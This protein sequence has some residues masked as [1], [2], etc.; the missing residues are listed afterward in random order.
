MQKP[1][2]IRVLQVIRQGL[3]GG[4]E[5][6]VIDIIKHIDR[7]RFKT[8][9]LS[10][11]DGPMISEI[12]KYGIPA[13]VISTNRAFDIPIWSSISKFI[14]KKQIELI[15][16]HGSRAQ[17]NVFWSALTNKLPLLYTVHGWSFHDDQSV[18]VRN[19]RGI[20]EK[21]LVRS[22][23]LVVNVSSSN[24]ATG[25]KRIGDYKGITIENGV[26]LKK[27]DSSILMTSKKKQSLG[28]SDDAVIIGCIMRMTK[29]KNPLGMLEAFYQAKQQNDKLCLLLVGDG[30]LMPEIRKFVEQHGLA[31]SVCITGS[32]TDVP[33]LL[34]V[35]D[36]FCLPSLWEGLPLSLLEAMAMEKAIIATNVDGT[37]ELIEDGSNGFLINPNDIS[38]I[39]ERILKLA[40]DKKLRK[41]FGA[42]SKS[43]IVQKHDVLM[44]VDKIQNA[45]LSIIGENL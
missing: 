20:S 1:K 19:L 17:S 18:I 5:S 3:I 16:A 21:L 9:V 23:D 11:T 25:V 8:Y 38:G 32:R 6:H 44:M 22:A 33:E 39:S 37:L 41:D 43:I 30:D 42:R 14:S 27:Y 40:D 12:A 45:Y 2:K 4:G 31:S 34:S 36:I 28:I 35:I 24:K 10:F 13:E 29:Q 7:S 26:D 15:H